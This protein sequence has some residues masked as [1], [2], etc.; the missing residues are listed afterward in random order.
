MVLGILNKLLTSIYGNF[1][2]GGFTV[3]GISY[4]SNTIN[5]TLIATLIASIPIG[6][7]CT[8][9]VKD[10]KV[11]SYSQQMV[12]MGL[13]LWLSVVA[14]WYF[15]N[16][17]KFNKYKSVSYSMLVYLVLGL[18]VLVINA[19]SSSKGVAPLAEEG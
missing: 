18:A 6:M 13:V 17:R 7:P 15:I 11:T 8:I 12:I 10:E 14:N 16:K 4:F 9:F 2:I 5:N 1:L 3:A 19:F